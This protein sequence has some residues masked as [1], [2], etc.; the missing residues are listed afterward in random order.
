MGQ[1]K[2][3][4][5]WPAGA[6]GGLGVEDVDRPS[7]TW[8]PV[9]ASKNS[10]SAV[11]VCPG[12]SYQHL[13]IDHEGKQVAEWL[14]QHGINAV[15]LR[16]R[17]AP[18]YR[19]PAP[20]LDAQRAIRTVR[21]RAAELKIAPDRIGI[22]GFSAGGHLASTTGTHFHSGKSDAPD[23]LD[24]VSSRPDFMV[25]AYPVISM[26]SEFTHATSRWNLLG[27]GWEPALAERL[28][29][30]KLVTAQTPPTFLFHTTEDTGVPPENSILFYLALRRAKVPAEMHIY[31]TGAHGV[32]LAQADPA[33][34][35]WPGRLLDWFR[36]RGILPR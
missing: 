31:E 30:D 11:I 7:L 27:D 36:T 25:L 5:L 10:G 22:W 15:L 23:P 32:G 6:P 4:L 26:T 18:K 28:S 21:A 8:Y 29:T 20:L 24:R 33:L 17:H 13:A 9:E 12:G 3:E 16:Y 1:L 19:H 14:N 35:S 34:S 2:T